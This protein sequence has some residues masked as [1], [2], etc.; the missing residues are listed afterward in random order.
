MHSLAAKYFK[1]NSSYI[2][3]IINLNLA[4][5]TIRTT[6]LLAARYCFAINTFEHQRC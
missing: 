2:Y 5:K 1:Y 6:S 4:L 3:K